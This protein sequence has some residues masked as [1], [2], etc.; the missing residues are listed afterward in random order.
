MIN[1][2]Q[3]KEAFIATVEKGIDLI[4]EIKSQVENEP[5]SPNE[6]NRL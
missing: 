2:S 5:Q 3:P 6:V 4:E 1:T